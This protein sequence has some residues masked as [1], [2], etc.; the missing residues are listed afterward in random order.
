[1]NTSK[2]FLASASALAVLSLLSACGGGGNSADAVANTTA[3]VS[4]GTGS[5]STGS[6]VATPTIAV[7]GKVLNVGYL[8]NTQ[9]CADLDDDGL[10]GA[11]EPSTTTNAGG[12]YALTLPTGKRG[13]SLL[14]VVRPTSTDS[15][16]TTAAPIAVQ[17]G[18]TLPTL[19]E[20]ADGATSATQ[21][22]TP[23]TATYYARI[24]AAGRNRLSNQIAMFTRI[25]NETNVDKVTGALVLP[26][27]FDYVANPRNTLATRLQGMH[28]VLNT[29]ATAAGAPLSMLAT[30][31][32]HASWYS[33]Y[34]APTATVA[35]VPVDAAKIAL[36]A[37]TSTSTPEYYVA[38][39]FHYFRPNSPAALRLR[40]GLAETAGWIRATGAGALASLDR[41]ATTLA[42]GSV[43][44]ALAQWVSGVWSSLTVDEVPYFTLNS[45]GTVVLNKATDYLQPRSITVADGNRVSYS[46]LYNNST[47]GFDVSDSPGTSFFINEWIDEQGDYTSYYNG[48]APV[49]ARVATAPAACNLRYPGS[50]AAAQNTDATTG[51]GTGT[52]AS[53]WYSTCFDYYLAEYYDKVKGDLGLT[54]QDAALPGANFYDATLKGSLVV[55]PATTTCGT[56][57]I[58][59]AKV[60]TAGQSHCNWAV[61][62]QAGHTLADLFVAGGVAINSWTKVYGSTSFTT[63]GVTTVRTAGTAAQAGLPQQMVLTLNRSGSATSGTGTL[64]SPYG[65]WTATSYTA[66]TEAVEWRISPE[67]P[68]MVLLS[69]PFRDINDPR[70]KTNTASDGTAA[71]AASVLPAG[72]FTATWNGN[73]FSAAPATHTAPNYRKLAI[74]LQDGVFVTGQ[75]YGTGYTYNERYFTRPAMD[76]G[77]QGMNYILAKLYAAGFTD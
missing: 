17:Q 38:Q 50:T 53:A 31:A 73:T 33:T 76:D 75:Y 23:I 13:T 64:T 39:D 47:W 48:T 4:T 15:A 29:R 65:A 35:A 24:R 63:G 68:N 70:V 61:N 46:N 52:T 40:E 3:S 28:N 12:A 6:T 41:R 27:D 9:V 62:A 54:L 34:V 18:W 74:L 42:N 8:G 77:I 55:A 51:A 44:Y 16:S 56:D 57:A 7:S 11:T 45:A 60:T 14:A 59:L 21:N 72:H 2:T 37:S 43:V 66:T 22:I 25:V 1:M 26:V 49:T 69:W 36:Y 67:N 71:V 5:T 30:T 32:V 10:C 19:L 58:P 20:Y